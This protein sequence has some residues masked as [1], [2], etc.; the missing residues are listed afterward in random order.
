V[1]ILYF[2]DF[3]LGILRGTDVVDVSSIVQNVPHTGP[4]D[5]ISNFIADFG[6]YKDRLEK[7]AADVAGVAVN[8]MEDGTRDAPTPINAFHKAPKAVIGCG[9]TMILPDVPATVFEGEAELGA[10]ITKTATNIL[11]ENAMDHIFGYVNFIDSSARNLPP[12][13]NT[14]F[15]VKSRDTFAPIGP[16]IVTAD[17]IDDPQSLQVRLWNKGKLMQNFNTDDMAHTIPRCIE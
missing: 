13:G 10:V 5:L 9:D 7:A 6:A 2:D 15:Q 11:A 4:H 1:K 16:Y 3:K 12:Y 17:E 8:Y 14:F